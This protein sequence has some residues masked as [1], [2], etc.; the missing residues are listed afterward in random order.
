MIRF[1]LIGSWSN[2]GTRASVAAE[3]SIHQRRIAN[4][5]G[6]MH[7]AAMLDE[8]VA[9]IAAVFVLAGLV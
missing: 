4:A 8:R 7:F 3:G 9:F 2:S 6:R 5:G 1:N